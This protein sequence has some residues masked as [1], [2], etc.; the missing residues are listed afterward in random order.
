MYNMTHVL[1]TSRRLLLWNVI[2]Y[3]FPNKAVL[4]VI[5]V[6]TNNILVSS[7]DKISAQ[8]IGATSP[9]HITLHTE[10]KMQT[11]IISHSAV[12]L[13]AHNALWLATF[14]GA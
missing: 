4:N 1:K 5:K 11:F 8:Q 12:L 9:H 6:A 13:F 2:R 10:Q 3:T 14:Y 7:R